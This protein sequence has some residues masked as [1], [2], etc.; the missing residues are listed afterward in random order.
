MIKGHLETGRR[1][2][3]AHQLVCG[4]GFTGVG[5][6]PNFSNGVRIINTQSLLPVNYTSMKWL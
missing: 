6:S 4:R 5:I 2:R 3:Q 1:A